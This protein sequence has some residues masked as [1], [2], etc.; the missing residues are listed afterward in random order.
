M[1]S[2][3]GLPWVEHY[4]VQYNIGKRF[5]SRF[6]GSLSLNGSQLHP[7]GSR[8]EHNLNLVQALKK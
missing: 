3:A 7:Q 4:R 5:V 2:A 6:C 1:L 8:E